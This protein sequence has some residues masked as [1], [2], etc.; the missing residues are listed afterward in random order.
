MLQGRIG[1]GSSARFAV[2]Q[3]IID[4]LIGGKELA[5]VVDQLSGQ[6]DVRSNWVSTVHW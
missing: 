1:I 5:E 2:A 3:H 6:T 4:E